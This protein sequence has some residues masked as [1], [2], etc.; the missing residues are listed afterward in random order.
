MP[1]SGGGGCGEPR[2]SALGPRARE[3]ARRALERRTEAAAESLEVLRAEDAA[4]GAA[5]AAAQVEL[6]EA[7]AAAEQKASAA[8]LARETAEA[9]HRELEAVCVRAHQPERQLSGLRDELEEGRAYLAAY[10]AE[11]AKLLE[12]Q[13]EL[14]LQ[15]AAQKQELR[16]VRQGRT[17]RQRRAGD[18]ARAPSAVGFSRGPEGVVR[19]SRAPAPPHPKRARRT[20]GGFTPA[21]GGGGGGGVAKAKAKAAQ[22]RVVEAPRARAHDHGPKAKVAP[23]P[24]GAK[25]AV[26]AAWEDVYGG[27]IFA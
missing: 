5:T 18:P 9:R 6:A 11:A 14:I 1:R 3:A 13:S 24:K 10:R 20:D 23:K 19:G 26:D 4:L 2:G 25:G 27:Q 16:E 15:V 21:S 8:R 17:R 22:H 7:A 12:Q